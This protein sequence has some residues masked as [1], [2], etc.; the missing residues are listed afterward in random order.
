MTTLEK[1]MTTEFGICEGETCW[2]NGC[3]GV[4][5]ED[6]PEN[7]RCHI[8]PPCGEC[9]TN[10]CWCPECDWSGRDE[11]DTYIVN[12]YTVKVNP[13]DRNGAYEWWKPRP[14]D[15]RKI[16][17]RNEGHTHFTMKK[18]GVYPVDEYPTPAEARA[19]IEPKVKGTFGGRFEYCSNGRFSYIAYTD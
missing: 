6:P 7:C 18:V 4:L 5:E 2:R 12:D 17:Y 8:N 3:Q 10:R 9:T 14:L 19:A 13:E 15:P 11:D 16:D 1:M